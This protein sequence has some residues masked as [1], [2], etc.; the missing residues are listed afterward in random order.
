VTEG[1]KYS[2]NIHHMHGPRQVQRV[3]MMGRA[4]K[5]IGMGNDAFYVM[6]KGLKDVPQGAF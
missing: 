2:L 3:G 1:L 6:L 5:P 4:S